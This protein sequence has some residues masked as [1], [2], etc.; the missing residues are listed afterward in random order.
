MKIM[1]YQSPLDSSLECKYGLSGDSLRGLGQAILGSVATEAALK[2]NL[3]GLGR[4]GE[5]ICDSGDKSWTDEVVVCCWSRRGWWWGPPPLYRSLLCLSIT[6]WRRLLGLKHTGSSSGRGISFL[7][8]RYCQAKSPNQYNSLKFF[9]SKIKTEVD[10][11]PTHQR[12]FK[13]D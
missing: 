4:P 10:I 7:G 11:T 12:V 1:K 9:I 2:S 8:K 6:L 13:V 3:T 5:D